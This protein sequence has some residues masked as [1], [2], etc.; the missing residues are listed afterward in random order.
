[1]VPN[2]GSCISTSFSG[3]PPA[4]TGTVAVTADG[5]VSTA[6]TTV[7]ASG[8][9]S[10][11][12]SIDGPDY[13]Q[14]VAEPAGAP[15]ETAE[16]DNAAPVISVASAVSSAHPG[17]AIAGT[18]TVTGLGPI[19]STAA[20]QLLGPV[21]TTSDCSSVDWTDAAIAASGTTPVAA[22]VKRGRT[23][24]ILG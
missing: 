17:D 15:S 12:V 3:A 18:I 22:D 23:P 16:V 21:A 6:P 24:F 2:L 7:G 10:Y 4:A 9:Y 20:W 5:T 1:M 14:T 11:A 19:G 8:C 13:A